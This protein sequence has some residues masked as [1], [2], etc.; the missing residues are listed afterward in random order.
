MRNFEVR[1]LGEPMLSKWMSKI[2]MTALCLALLCVAS[3]ALLAQSTTQGAI[4]GTVFDSTGA[5]LPNATVTIHRDAT[6]A[7]QKLIS[8]AS[9]NFIAPL[10]EPGTYTVTIRAAG[11]GAVTEHSVIVQVGQP[12]TLLPHLVIGA[13]AQTVEVTSEAPVLN[14]ES[15]SFSSNLNLKA[16]EDIPI[17]R[18][19]EH[20]S[21]L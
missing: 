10:V 18:S 14:L 12:T 16:M 11:F 1:T 9:G 6:N 15:P 20:T 13:A 5:V 17:N 2:K 4:G 8:D 7:E 3:V 19:E 21:E